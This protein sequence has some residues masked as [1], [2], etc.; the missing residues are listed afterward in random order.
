[1]KFKKGD[2]VVCVDE[3]ITYDLKKGHVYIVRSTALN[4]VQVVGKSH[5]ISS[6]R[7]REATEMD[8]ALEG[9]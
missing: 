1:V 8:K 3:S 4:H 6:E 5:Y 2:I 9:L 7:F